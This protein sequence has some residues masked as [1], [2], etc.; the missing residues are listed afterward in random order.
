MPYQPKPARTDAQR[1]LRALRVDAR[2]HLT[3]RILD[4]VEQALDDD[5]PNP[6]HAAARG[7]EEILAA[8]A[9]AGVRLP[10]PREEGEDEEP[11]RE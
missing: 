1:S 5:D 7:W 6:G 10:K 9:T 3:E 4:I 8:F 11:W 2:T